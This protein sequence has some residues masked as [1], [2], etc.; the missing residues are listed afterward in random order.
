MPSSVPTGGSTPSPPQAFPPPPP[1]APSASV[2]HV[3]W[4]PALRLAL[5]YLAVSA[6]W[7]AFSDQLLARLIQEPQAITLAQT[8]KGWGFVA[9]SAAILFVLVRR[10]FRALE[11]AAEHERWAET[12][13]RQAAD[14]VF[15]MIHT[16]PLG[17]VILGPDRRVALWSPGAERIFGWNSDEVIGQDLPTVPQDRQSE[18]DAALQ[19]VLDGDALAGIE[20]TGRRKDH[21]PV[22]LR[23]WAAPL[24]DEHGRVSAVFAMFED[25]SLSLEAE[26][27]LRRRDAAL[28]ALG[29]V[30][31][32]LL[33]PGDLPSRL[34]PVLHRLGHALEASRAYVFEQHP[35]PLGRP[36]ISRRSE[37]CAPGITP[38]I[39]NPELQN[40]PRH[41]SP[42]APW[43]D[44]LERGE[45][46]CGHAW[47]FPD[48]AP[49]FMEPEDI[50][51]IL[52]VPV[53]AGDT[54]WGL[55][56][57]DEC[58]R[59]RQWS[60]AEIEAARAAAGLLGAVIARERAIRE[61]EAS[62]DRYRRLVDNARDVIFR[63]RLAPERGFEYVSPAVEQLT[64]F[65]PQDLERLPDSL[66]SLVH[67]EDRVQML[68]VLEGQTSPT[69]TLRLRWKHRQGHAVWVEQSTSP[70][71]DSQGRMVALEG[72]ARD[73]TER[74]EAEA[75]EHRLVEQLA[76]LHQTSLDITAQTALDPLLRSIVERAARLIGTQMAGLFLTTA[77]G[78]A[79]EQ[80]IDYG[81]AEETLGLRLR[82]GEGVLG[83]AAARGEPFMV[84]NHRTWPL[85]CE[86]FRHSAA[87]R[88][89]AVPLRTQGKTLGVLYLSD[90]AAGTFSQD[91]IRLA[92]L[93]AEQAAVALQNARL[94]DEARRHTHQME[95]LY[96]T[97]VEITAQ[98]DV[99]HLLSAIV[100]RA[101]NL[102]NLPVG[103][104]YLLDE[105]SRTL[106]LV[107]SRF[108]DRDFKGT[109]IAVGEG[110]A[111]QA[112][113]RG[114]PVVIESYSDWQ[115]RPPVYQDV[116]TGRVLAVPLRAGDR[117]TGAVYVSDFL[118]GA[119]TPAE[120]QLVTLLADQAAVAL[121]NARLLTAE[122]QR[123]AELRRSRSL[124]QSLSRMA[125]DLERSTHPDEL[126]DTLRLEL[127][128]LGLRCW[129]GF[130]DEATGLLSTR[131][132]AEGEPAPA[133]GDP[134]LLE[135]TQHLVNRPA[136]IPLF[137]DVLAG[138]EPRLVPADE[139]ARQLVP[140]AMQ[141]QLV[142]PLM[143]AA[144]AGP[145]SS[146]VALRL[147]RARRAAGL[148]LLWGDRLTPQDI[149]ALATFSPQVSV[150][151]EKA[152]LLDQIRRRAAYLEALTSVAA[153]LRQASDR[154]SM[155]SIIIGQLMALV[156]AQ[157][158]W[159]AWRDPDNGQ[160]IIH[161]ASGAWAGSSGLRLQ[162][163]E[164]IVGRVI[165][166]GHAEVYA[167]PPA[168][169]PLA[170]P[171]LAPAMPAIACIPLTVQRETVGCLALGRESPFRDDDLR[172]LTAVADMAGNA[173]HR[174]GVMETLEARVSQ[175]TEELERANARLQELDRLKSDFVSNVTH[176]LR[177]PITNILLYLD[178]LRAA[179][180]PERSLQH[181]GVLKSEAMRLGRLIEDLLTLSRFERGGLGTERE[182]HP[183][184]PLLTQVLE[185]LA[186]SA[187]ARQVEL[188]H[189]PNLDLPV[190]WIHPA[191]ILQ[192]LTN[193]VGNA[194]AY[195]RLGGHVRLSTH[196]RIVEGRAFVGARV[197]HDGPPIDP[198]DLPHLFE[199]FYRGRAARES[200]QP[201][202]GL[203]L[204]ISR[205]IVERQGGWIDVETD[206]AGTAF[207]VWLPTSAPA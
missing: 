46:V 167:E 140:Q 154:Q 64:G 143:A 75:A 24:R 36:V 135:A 152:Q 109:R 147:M 63:Y 76:G 90:E 197:F 87:G 98:T 191:Q 52:L 21:Q 177:T 205:E 170:R 192:V 196:Q 108:P 57:F 115:H 158:A 172:L 194:I 132:L 11:R 47:H 166:T 171:D 173:L 168:D 78:E 53:F 73:V 29:S 96:Q 145:N 203:G 58:T 88:I 151:L 184:D 34:N 127:Q 153:A 20:I 174:A 74:V 49:V 16:T 116:R 92:M 188:T 157:A 190:A 59:E 159:L 3:G 93:F 15:A 84:E 70:V 55:L 28:A 4:R 202:T 134:T 17:V 130:V 102:L 43:G 1:H 91:E 128:D 123:S 33:L 185:T 160:T 106:E 85:R 2:Y 99:G 42:F 189:E 103:G 206:P 45:V 69:G 139:L 37:W 50:R 187:L 105:A 183:L 113:E 162:P 138:G 80:V 126:L 79:L 7:I 67:P 38:Q 22:R 9:V 44:A 175:R 31:H 66:V 181:L 48:I 114:E 60:L 12:R 122:R 186:P 56:G 86:A 54:W 121:E 51:S 13:V 179:S 62:E 164:G 83:I 77:D 142:G 137:R 104:V 100:D 112:V 207:T 18:T 165:A 5:I 131:Y 107:V 111:G 198:E 161:L 23:L 200:G 110:A 71:V 10:E 39:A 27:A 120:I 41:N 97:A 119:F 65:T 125:A 95:A 19:R 193:L 144:Q 136:D 26:E 101:T 6:V 148:F 129:I 117:I 141:G 201:G 169:P 124:I 82:L 81:R 150:A 68:R 8:L 40:L 61:M 30:T 195:T 72:I 14:Q 180:S 89:L 149:P 118:P 204:A 25:H 178:L 163:G 155:E 94:F 176:E 133:R 146:A 156:D 199:R 32:E 35:G 182:T